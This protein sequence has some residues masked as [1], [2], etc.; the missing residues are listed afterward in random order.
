MHFTARY[1]LATAIT[2]SHLYKGT[3]GIIQANSMLTVHL[4][5]LMVLILFYPLLMAFGWVNLSSAPTEMACIQQNMDVRFRSIS[6]GP[7]MCINFCSAVLLGIGT[8]CI[9]DLYCYVAACRDR[10]GFVAFS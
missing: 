8:G 7:H 10:T 1:C 2:L 9:I 4:M 3:F 6:G 5:A